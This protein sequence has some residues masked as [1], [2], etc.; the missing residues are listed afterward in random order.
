MELLPFLIV[1]GTIIGRGLNITHLIT[2][3]VFFS[4]CMQIFSQIFDSDKSLSLELVISEIKASMVKFLYF[5]HLPVL[6][7][8][9]DEIAFSLVIY[10]KI[11]LILF[12]PFATLFF[13]DLINKRQPLII[14]NHIRLS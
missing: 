9:C 11:T 14:H 3:V 8:A 5:I 12:K 4:P 13:N 7:N 6:F 1:V 2:I 10:G